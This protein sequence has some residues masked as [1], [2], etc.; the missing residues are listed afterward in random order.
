[1]TTLLVT[2]TADGTGKTA[3]SIA[4]ARLAQERGARVGYMKPKGTRLESVVGKTRDADPGFAKRVLGLNAD[5]ETLEPVVYSPTFVRE[6]IRGR[7]D[8]AALRERIVESFD[9]L[10][11]DCDLMV[12]EGGGRLWTGGI[13]ELTDA[14]V[15]RLLDARA[16]LVS[17]YDQPTDI[18]DVLAAATRLED[19]LA[20][21]LFNAVSDADRDGLTEDTVPFLEGRGVETVGALPYD[22][23]LAGVSVAE[24]ADGIGAELLTADAPTDGLVERFEVGA[25]GSDA[26]FERFGQ[27]RN[28]AVITGGDRSDV[29]ATALEATGVEC[30]VLTGGYRPSKAV[31]GKA[32]T[33]GVPLLLVRTNTR[34]TID[35]LEGKLRSG[36]VRDPEAI[37]RVQTLLEHSIDTE[38]LLA[39]PE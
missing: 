1:M 5:V 8:P 29:Q 37:A 25:M 21:V 17:H 14:D 15:A 11:A 26:A 10:S 19:Y 33:R 2:S 23:Q 38:R 35:R 4:L 31:V 6:A 3:I 9:S 24:I 13:V 18:D 16:V 30:L 36:R 12:V 39:L 28:T 27:T 20:G 22:D 34:T 32:E 7:A